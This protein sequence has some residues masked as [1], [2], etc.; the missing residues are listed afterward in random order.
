[1]TVHAQLSF[2]GDHAPS[3]GRERIALL[4]ALGREGSISG[5]ARVVGISYKAAWDAVDAM[6]NLFGQPLV[7]AK[8]GGKRG[9]GAR[10]TAGG[11]QVIETFHRLEG[12]LA[13]MLGAID[14][15]LVGSG[16]AVNSLIS[17]FF[18]RT[19]ARNALRGKI[20]AVTDGAVNAEVALTVSDQV[21]L[22]A[23]ITRD[24]VRELGLVPGREA[25]ALI[26]SSFLI[27]APADQ[28][29]RTSVRNRI[30]G[31]I[32]RREDGAVNTELSLDIGGGKT[33][34]SIVTRHS[35][36]DLGFAAGQPACALVDAS[37]IILAVD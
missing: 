32:A 20:S 26:K 10:L 24:S 18:M 31:V 12:E 11:V 1:M 4:E 6:N 34:I 33:L 8:P 29:R 9:G 27:L 15:E 22:T 17:G 7:E 5:A 28:A 21:T 19:S 3:A 23:I 30:E 14:A 16:I 35:A 25:T 36:D 13:R 2:G 37:H